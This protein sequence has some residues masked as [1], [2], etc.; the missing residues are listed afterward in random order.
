MTE[1]VTEPEPPGVPSFAVSVHSDALSSS[2]YEP[3]RYV[4][5]MGSR[6]ELVGPEPQ[7]VFVCP[8]E[9][10]L[11]E[12]VIFSDAVRLSEVVAVTVKV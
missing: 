12:K 8:D 9:L 3:L 10:L 1:P 11:T 2:I 6:Q 7:P 5:G 4:A